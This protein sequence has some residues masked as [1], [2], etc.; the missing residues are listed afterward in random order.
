MY[1]LRA[2]SQLLDHFKAIWTVFKAVRTILKPST[3]ACGFQNGPTGFK[4]VW[5][6]LKLSDSFA[7]MP[8][9]QHDNKQ[10]CHQSNVTMS[11]DCI[12]SAT[13]SKNAMESM[14]MS[15][16]AIESMTTNKDAI[17]STT[18]SKDSFKNAIRL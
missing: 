17:V 9:K 13:T 15:K 14:T 2:D 16:D 5:P 11:E 1:V 18:T 4:A 3:F 7:T 8:S 12:K 10:G 6:A